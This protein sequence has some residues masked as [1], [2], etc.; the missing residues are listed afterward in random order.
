MASDIDE[1]LESL[2]GDPLIAAALLRLRSELPGDLKY[3]VASHTDDVLREVVLFATHDGL[4]ARPRHLLAIAAAYHDLGFVKQRS[5]NE[6]V[7]AQMAAEAMHAAG[8]F[9][10][11]EIELVHGMILDTQVRFTEKGPQQVPASEL[12]KYLLDADVSNLGREDFFDKAELVRQEVQFEN[13]EDFMRGLVKFMEAHTWY[14][15]AAKALRDQKKRENQAKLE[16][17]VRTFP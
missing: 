2:K 17:M 7:G 8:G 1:Q 14:T 13:K 16:A 6:E 5:N 4:D 15:P 12:S 11:S 9:R 3:H 10:A